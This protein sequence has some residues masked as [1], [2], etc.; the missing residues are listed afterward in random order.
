MRAI[1]VSETGGPERLEFVDVPDPIP[2]AS[3]IVVEVAAAG[4]NYIDTYHRTGL[5]PLELPFIPGREGAGVVRAVAADVDRW[6]EGDRVAWPG[7]AGSYA[8]LTALD[9]ERVVAVPEGISLDIAAA[10]M[11]QGL[12]AHYLAND[13]FAL[14]RGSSCLI[15]AGAGGVG[16]LLI[17]MAKSKGATVFT[18]VSTDEKAEMASAAGADHVINYRQVDFREAI[19]EIA[20]SKP[21]DVVYDGV[22][23]ST[24]DDG[25]EL[26][27]PRGS[28]VLYGQSSGV[29][30]PFDL[31]RLARSGSLFITRP[32]LFHHI[33]GR[34]EL[35]ARSMELFEAIGSGDLRIHV[36][37]TF[38]LSQAS[39]AHEDLEA[40][41]TV[42]K[43]LL[44][45]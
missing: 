28:M 7:E 27:R 15:H 20:G 35:E 34:E 41:R 25:L 14:R 1:L 29:V 40:R 18:T 12:T 6:Q 8:E 11:L 45:P 26:I 44:E 42:G 4:V 9:A 36:G 22:G 43:V 17:Q 33:A 13:S 38:P 32:S 5:Y 31:G 21:L 24:F 23:A 19:E 30:P 2:A 10:S 3:E 39:Q 37:S 16:Q